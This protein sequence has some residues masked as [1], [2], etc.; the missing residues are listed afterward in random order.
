MN[1]LAIRTIGVS[2]TLMTLK[3]VATKVRTRPAAFEDEDRLR[4]RGAIMRHV[5]HNSGND[6]YI[7]IDLDH[8]VNPIWTF[9]SLQVIKQC[10][11]R[12]ML[13]PI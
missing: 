12:D 13:A 1:F 5:R 7:F 6:K 10:I 9:G 2:G 4:K 11:R 3:S 8:Y